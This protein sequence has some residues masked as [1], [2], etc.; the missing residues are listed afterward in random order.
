MIE[1]IGKDNDN[2]ITK[3][4]SIKT[5][6]EC[7]YVKQKTMKEEINL[8]TIRERSNDNENERSPNVSEKS[9][10]KERKKI[11]RI[12]L[13]SESEA[14]EGN[15]L[16]IP[17]KCEGSI[18]YVHKLCIKKW[19]AINKIDISNAHC[20]ICGTKFNIKVAE[21]LKLDKKKAKSFVIQSSI[22]MMIIFALLIA[23]GVSLIKILVDKN[24]INKD[25]LTYYYLGVFSIIIIICS[26]I[27]FCIVI[28]YKSRCYYKEK[29]DWEVLGFVD[30]S[31][32]NT[33]S[34]QLIKIPNENALMNNYVT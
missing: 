28:E 2:V 12:C 32:M 22:F 7:L 3:T 29:G 26:I 31:G 6:D 17:C 34:S 9:Q 19:I 5:I 4:P 14:P 16:I 21:T 8:S 25:S 11:C 10:V 33:S 18:K 24:M 13:E 15:P 23:F 20:E 1:G 27:I 30:K